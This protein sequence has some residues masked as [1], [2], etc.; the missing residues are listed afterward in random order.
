MSWKEFI[1]DRYLRNEFIITI[2][3]FI[4]ILSCFTVFL[5]FNETRAGVTLA[6]PILHFFNAV[7]LTW[8]IF[9]IVYLSIVLALFYLVRNPAEFIFAIQV[10]GLLLLIRLLMMFLIPLNPPEG[11]IS[12]NDPFVQ[13]LGTGKLLTKDLFFSGHTATIFMLYLII[14]KKKYKLTFFVL[15]IIVGVSVLLQHVHYAIDV[16]AAPFFAYLA[17]RLVFLF[18]TKKLKKALVKL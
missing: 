13:G 14:E 3:F 12:L 17:Y 15:T 5:K 16:A 2:I 1:R 8:P 6:D 7:D 9:I 4:I 10:Y 18:Q 11:M